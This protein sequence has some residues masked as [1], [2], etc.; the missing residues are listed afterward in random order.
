MGTDRRRRASWTS[1]SPLRTETILAKQ[2]S[3]SGRG[4]GRKPVTI[5]LSSEEVKRA[6]PDQPEAGV[7]PLSESS[8]AQVAADES[9]VGVE[10]PDSGMAASEASADA[11]SPAG[12][13]GSRAPEEP[14]AGSRAEAE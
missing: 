3:R 5:D 12:A 4:G 13:W 9:A 11:V 14:A 8:G 10:P 1:P 2:T 7:A 6:S